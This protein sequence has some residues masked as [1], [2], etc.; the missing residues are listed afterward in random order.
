MKSY[1][2]D[3][4]NKKM[5]IHF[6]STYPHSTGGIAN[7]S[8][9]LI[10]ELKLIKNM[11]VSFST[12]DY[13]D[14]KR[15]KIWI[16]SIRRIKE[17]KPDIIHFQYGGIKTWGIMAP[18]FIMF[19]KLKYKNIKLIL[20]SHEKLSTKILS[21]KSKYI[22]S[23][24]KYIYWFYEKFIYLNMDCIIVHTKEHRRVMKKK[25]AQESYIIPHF[26]STCDEEKVNEDWKEKFLQKYRNRILIAT[27]GFV[28]RRKNYEDV[29]RVMNRLDG[30]FIYLI[31][32]PIMDKGYYKQLIE[33]ITKLN[34]DERIIFI[35]KLND[36]EIPSFLTAIDILVLPYRDATQS[37]VLNLAVGHNVNIIATKL[38]GFEEILKDYPQGLLYSGGNE[39]E[40]KEKIINF[41]EIVS[42]KEKKFFQS[43]F[44]LKSIAR[45]HFEL[46][47]AVLEKECKRY[48]I[49]EKL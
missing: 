24:I 37:G 41:N 8:K 43:Q 49:Y 30:S 12:V 33:T 21:I 9:K 13:R 34:L 3:Q 46:Y 44:S 26:I 28:N 47:R 18:I 25:Y 19:L 11:E 39:E 35:G 31:A 48:R 38:P 17:V 36:D 29:I 45:K 5:K 10:N 6:I 22:R 16:K 7:Y 2:H 40:L 42:N 23:I 4:E 27:F 14:K 32:G 15:N 20:T 1:Q